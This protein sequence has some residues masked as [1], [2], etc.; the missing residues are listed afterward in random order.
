MAFLHLGSNI[1]S[2]CGVGNLGVS[3][4]TKKEI[5]EVLDKHAKWLRCEAVGS[6]A[7]L[8]RA[9]LSRADLSRA[10]LSGANLSGADLSGANLS[11]ANLSLE[12]MNKFLP[13]C[14]PECG[15]FVAWK[16]S[17]GGY[18]IK[19]EVTETAKRSSAYGRKCRCSEAKVLAIE[20]KDGNTADAK[21]AC[22]QHDSSFIYR[23]GEIVA[24]PNFDKDRRNECAP[25]IHFFITRQE[26]VDY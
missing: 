23:V 4:M 15:S 18:I 19:L 7:D 25:G 3:D 26:A 22:S 24:V 12:L 1:H 13:I 11:G 10:D 2:F 8:S 21:E 20:T 5:K 9:D 14:C 17:A 16:K 6:R